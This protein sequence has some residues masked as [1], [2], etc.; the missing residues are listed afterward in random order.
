MGL[1]I[2]TVTLVV[3]D[4]DTAIAWFVGKLGFDVLEDTV[5]GAGKRWV[6]VAPAGGGV[7][8]LL[9]QAVGDAQ[10][11]SIGTQ[12]GGRVA[13]FLETDDIRRDHNRFLTDGVRFREAPRVE[14]YGTVAVFED[15]CGNPWDL[16][17]PLKATDRD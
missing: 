16:I 13:F 4:Y 11:A 9:A 14:P 1:R 2:A 12:A 7:A 17:E 8:L 15:L 5:I 6:K 10:R 3:E